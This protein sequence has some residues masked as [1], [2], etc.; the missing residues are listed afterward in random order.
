MKWKFEK[1]KED[2]TRQDSSSDKFFKEASESDSLIREFIQN[3]LDASN[4]SKAVKVTINEKFLNKREFKDFLTDLEPHLKAC[5]IQSHKNQQKIKFIILEDFNTK[6]LEGKNK[7]NF[8]KADNIT[9]KQE[10]GGSHGIG[11]AV[12]LAF[13]KIQTFFGYSIFDNNQSTFQGRAVLK[14]HKI[15]QHEYRPYGNLEIPIKNH[16]NFI[17]TIFKRKKTEKGLSVAIPYCD[18]KIEDIKQCCLDQFYIPIINEKLEVEIGNE[19]INK[20]TLLDLDEPK[21]Q[22][23]MD[24]NTL[25]KTRN[26]LIKEK[27]WKHLKFPELTTDLIEQNS[28]FFLSF[29]IELPTKQ[30]YYESGKATLLI[31]KEEENTEKFQSID[32]WRDNLLIPEVISRGKKQ[33]GYAAILIICD[34]P[35]SGLLR[36]LEDPGHTRWLTGFIK[37]EIKE[38][39]INV[40]KLVDFVKK[41]PLEFIRQ[42]KYQP[43]EQDSHFFSDYFPDISFLGKKQTREEGSDFPKGGKSIIPEEPQFQNFI[44]KPHKKGDGFSLSLK[45]QEYHPDKLTVKTAYGTN[46]GNAFSNYDKRDFIFEEN[47]AIKLESEKNSGEKIFCN[48]N[49]VTYSITDE[50]FCISFTG[51]DPD[52]ELKIDIK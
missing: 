31:K 52:K 1:Y 35:L 41:L 42:I 9:N 3:S 26:Y 15:D 39:Y 18:L 19:K 24:Y 51:F 38:K 13:S 21:V 2:S 30:G 23:A 40:R 50:K 45:K 25:D 34:T 16:T 6:G 48:E 8:F 7:E 29:E 17:D 32:F 33:K 28:S 5:D 27:D 46:K 10:G 12:F 43:I 37:P 36:G 14:S 4:N 22:L 11:K 47:I 49:S 44:Y 20:E